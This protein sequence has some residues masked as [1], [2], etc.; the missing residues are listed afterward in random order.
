[1]TRFFL[2]GKTFHRFFPVIFVNKNNAHLNQSFQNLKTFLKLVQAGLGS[3]DWQS[4]DHQIPGH[5]EDWV[6]L[7]EQLLQPEMRDCI[8]AP[9][10]RTSLM[11]RRGTLIKSGTTLSAFGPFF[12]WLLYNCMRTERVRWDERSVLVPYSLIQLVLLW[13]SAVADRF[14]RECSAQ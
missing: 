4:L 3:Y 9:G 14:L 10:E 12:P 6:F 8:G 7:L 2:W 13:C 1:M 5:P 11:W